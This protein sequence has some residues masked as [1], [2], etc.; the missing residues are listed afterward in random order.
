MEELRIGK[1]LKQLTNVE[2][3]DLMR[4][5]EHTIRRQRADFEEYETLVQVK[6][7]LERRDRIHRWYHGAKTDTGVAA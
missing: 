1:S 5:C 2:L 6:R 3:L 7:E 4:H